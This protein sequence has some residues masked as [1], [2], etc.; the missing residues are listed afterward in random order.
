MNPTDLL[1]KSQIPAWVVII[2]VVA[3]AVA[4]VLFK[5]RLQRRI[6]ELEH[7][8]KKELA[9]HQSD[10]E[11]V[12]DR[13]NKRLK[14]L[15]EVNAPL[16]E[17]EHALDHLRVGD[18]TYAK[19]LTEQSVKA[20]ELVR[21]HQTLLG[22]EFWRIVETTTD[23]GQ[24]VLQATFTLTEESLK[25]LEQSDL[26]TNTISM[27]RRM[28]GQSVPVVTAEHLV[29]GLD[30]RV[31]RRYKREIFF[32]CELSGEFNG[33][34]YQAAEVC[35]RNIKNDILSTLPRPASYD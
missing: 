34:K 30:E 25:Q 16:R 15:D 20:R 5:Y 3:A 26:P 14:A 24:G 8:L 27:L 4:M 17:F 35:L 22:D 29:N 11:S 21:K 12:Q 1:L 6:K 28:V 31:L 10:L 33:P 13:H 2:I 19:R 23:L 7:R 18:S 32:A 9:T